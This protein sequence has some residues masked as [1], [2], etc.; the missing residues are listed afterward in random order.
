MRIY[1]TGMN[2]ADTNG[3]KRRPRVSIFQAFV[4][5]MNHY[6]TLGE[7]LTWRITKV[8]DPLP[9]DTDAVMLSML[10]P[11][12]FNS[13]YALGAIWT[14]SE[15]LRLDIPLVLYFTDWAFFRAVVEFRSIAKAGPS[16][17]LKTIGGY[18][19]YDEP[20]DQV[21]LHGET[22]ID[23]CRQYD[24]PTSKLWKQ[25]QVLVPRY[26]NWGDVGIIQ[27]YLPGANPVL[28]M[29][30]TLLF[31]Q[32]LESVAPMKEPKEW[33]DRSRTWVLPSLLKDDTWLDKQALRWPIH[34]YGPKGFPVVQNE[35]DVLNAYG[36]ARGGLCPP[37]STV[38]SGWWRSRWI[39]SA[40]AGSLLLAHR[41]DSVKVGEEYCYDGP[42]YE[43]MPPA[44]Q[45]QLAKDQSVRMR[46]LMQMNP[47]MLVDQLYDPIRKAGA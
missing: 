21:R 31:V 24:T 45:H 36:D 18:P 26:T 37:Y 12:S 11:R 7:R 15:A 40:L 41:V 25:A 43:A 13:P 38:G 44:K 17:F 5:M 9:P 27:K 47:A 32:Y 1:A 39:H 35:R 4:A 29:D 46:G 6:R 30:P 10:L 34:R 42:E 20:E 33:A 23:V 14:I 8:G 28:T 19:Q 22:M 2:P 3:S 16:Y